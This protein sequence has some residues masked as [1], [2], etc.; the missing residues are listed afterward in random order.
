MKNPFLSYLDD[1]KTEYLTPLCS[2][3]KAVLK[4]VPIYGIDDS[5]DGKTFREIF[6]TQL[7]IDEIKSVASDYH[8]DISDYEDYML[9]RLLD[10]ALVS[11]DVKYNSMANRIAEKFGDRL[12]LL[13]LALKK[14]EQENRDARL[15]WEDIHWRYLRE[16]DTVIFVGG[17]ASSM[18][19]RRFKERIQ[20]IFDLANE[21]PYNIMLFD[22]GTYVG[23]MGCAQLM[24]DN[25]TSLVF[26]FG[27]T[28]LK[29]CVISKG[30]GEIRG[31]NA[32]DSVKS[33]YVGSVKD[34]E[35]AWEEALKLHKHLV[36]T[37]IDTYKQCCNDYQL[38]KE[39]IISIANYNAGGVL[40]AERGGYAKLT[41]LSND[42]AKLLNEDLSGMLHKEVKV[43][44]V[45][46]GTANALYFNEVENSICISLGTAFGVGF[47]DIHM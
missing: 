19:G 1:G 46:D 11:Q 4:K 13:L 16:L 40:N 31:F 22:N 39:I 10:K 6:S 24:K 21:K 20:H 9:P 15:D 35:D 47:T 34:N 12:G 18:L 30:V 2:L 28:N 14:G 42:Y 5:V 25:T 27:H 44:L 8:I 23:V 29:R 3:N 37:I 45:H 36:K 41:Q 43:R 38:S 17:L 33:K 7:V 26:D 32:F